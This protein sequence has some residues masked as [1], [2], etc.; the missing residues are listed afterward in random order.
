MSEYIPIVLSIVV[1]A[2]STYA[3][4]KINNIMNKK[5][6]IV[7]DL[8][9]LLLDKATNDPETQKRVY[10][11]G[12][13]IGNGVKEGLGLQK[14]GGRTGGLGGLVMQLLSGLLSKRLPGGQSNPVEDLLNQGGANS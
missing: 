6:Q 5:E 14:T 13:L 3:M 9:D 1:V 12:G 2:Q 10:L 11:L 8:F 7:E 4:L